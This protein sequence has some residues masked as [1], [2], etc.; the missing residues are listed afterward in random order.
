M[1]TKYILIVRDEISTNKPITDETLK[2]L[3]CYFESPVFD[4][5]GTENDLNIAIE[6]YKRNFEHFKN[7]S[8]ELVK[9]Q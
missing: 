5:E 2:A 4:A 7:W 9:A 3:D 1:K 8:A 6:K